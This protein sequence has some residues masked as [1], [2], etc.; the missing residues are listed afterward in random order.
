MFDVCINGRV[1]TAEVGGY[2]D[3]DNV[4]A[5][6]FNFDKLRDAET[7]ARASSKGEKIIRATVYSCYT[8]DATGNRETCTYVNGKRERQSHGYHIMRKGEGL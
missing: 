6:I 2:H 1:S 8:C 3:T 7:C 4:S 5:W